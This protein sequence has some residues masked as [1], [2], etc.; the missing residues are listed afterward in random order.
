MTLSIE[1]AQEAQNIFDY[2]EN[3]SCFQGKGYRDAAELARY[4][5]WYGTEVQRKGALAWIDFQLD[6][7]G[8]LFN[9]TLIRLMKEFFSK[10]KFIVGISL[11][12]NNTI[13]AT[14]LPT[15]ILS[16]IWGPF[17][18][19]DKSKTCRQKQEQKPSQ[20]T[21]EEAKSLLTH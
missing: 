9:S 12:T 6:K 2:L 21:I 19:L 11:A 14:G 5:M 18:L 20:G 13:P 8:A 3:K 17:A 7:H 10:S 16:L 4:F 15:L 1:E